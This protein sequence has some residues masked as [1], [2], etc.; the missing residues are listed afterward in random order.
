MTPM[1]VVAESTT[2]A[3]LIGIDGAD[4]A[5]GGGHGSAQ[6]GSR[7]CAGGDSVGGLCDVHG[8][9]DDIDICLGDDVALGQ[10]R[11]KGCYGQERGGD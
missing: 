5:H 10:G 11:R 3:I 4:R 8:F 6:S 7:C 2:E 9:V 1:T